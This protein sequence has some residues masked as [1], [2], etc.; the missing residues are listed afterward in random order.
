MGQASWAQTVYVNVENDAV[1]DF[2][3]EVS[4][5]YS[6]NSQILDYLSDD[7]TVRLDIP[8]PAVLPIP[9]TTAE[10]VVVS[11]GEMI[12]FSDCLTMEI[13][14]SEGQV[15]IYNLIP[16]RE[17][18]YKMEADGD[19]LMQGEIKTDGRV[20]MIY[21]PTAFNIR[22]MGGWETA[23]GRIIKYGKI[24]RGSELNGDNV[25]S[26]ADIETL[27]QLGIA[28]EIDM[29]ENSESDG[30]GISAF[31]FT[32]EGNSP[33]YLY[34]NNSGCCDRIHL[35]GYTWTQ[36][37]R[38]EFEFI[39]SN[40]RQGRPVYH[41]CI[42]GADRTGMLAFLLEGLLG[43]SYDQM[44]KDY[45]LTSFYLL[46]D[47]KQ[48]DFAYEYILSLNGET[49]QDKFKY[50]FTNRL[51]VS[52]A[53]INYFLEEMLEPR[54]LVGINELPSTIQH[55]QSTITYD[56]Q[57]RP[58]SSDAKGVRIQVDADGATRKKIVR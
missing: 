24:Y 52:Q 49:L 37:Y 26:E 20:R 10:K 56:L 28:A 18:F 29:R 5:E 1:Q 54:V 11:Y 42:R 6:T 13:P 17:Y 39:I 32:S 19:V 4:Y 41:H 14:V 44:M 38:K 15:S 46:R 50:Y 47:K 48:M 36:R 58:I 27:R 12:D 33:T 34:T 16:N 35:T 40:L 9:E 45:E 51:Y 22:D 53:N 8:R 43:V 31:G 57:G 55:P 3:D 23:D 21:V 2:L 30:A 25:A 7:S